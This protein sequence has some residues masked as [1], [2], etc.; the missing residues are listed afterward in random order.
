MRISGYFTEVIWT[1][2]NAE[3]LNRDRYVCK[4]DEAFKKEYNKVVIAVEKESIAMEIKQQLVEKFIPLE[5]IYWKEPDC[6]SD[7]FTFCVR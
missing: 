4:T 2:S 6:I 5:K 3:K 1:D 7:T